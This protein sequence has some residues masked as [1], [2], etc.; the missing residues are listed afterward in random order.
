MLQLSTEFHAKLTW[1]FLH[2]LADRQANKQHL[3]RFT[4]EATTWLA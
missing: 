1:Q 4:Y 3:V 2:N